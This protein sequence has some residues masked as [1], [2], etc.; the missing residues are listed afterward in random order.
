MAKM[1]PSAPETLE[2]PMNG[3][4]P[5]TRLRQR[6]MDVDRECW[7][8]MSGMNLVAGARFLAARYGVQEP[9]LESSDVNDAAA[10]L[11]EYLTMWTIAPLGVPVHIHA[12][13]TRGSKWW[14]VADFG[15]SPS[16]STTRADSGKLHG[17]RLT[18]KGVKR[19]VG[20]G[21][22]Y[23]L[24]VDP[25]DRLGGL[26]TVSPDWLQRENPRASIATRAR[27]LDLGD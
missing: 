13:F 20:G 27:T 2:H 15:P 9:I 4:T 23:V 6:V 25:D 17:K 21:G 24:C 3:D 10:L 12:L 18:V 19:T 7:W 5:W 11:D 26:I 1:Y 16:P 14:V 22:I 8:L